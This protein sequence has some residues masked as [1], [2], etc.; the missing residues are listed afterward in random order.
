[1]NGEGKRKYEKVEMWKFGKC[2][3]PDIAS[4]FANDTMTKGLAAEVNPLTIDYSL[5]THL[6]KQGF[7]NSYTF[8][9]TNVHPFVAGMIVSKNGMFFCQFEVQIGQ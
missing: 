2:V 9:F 6:R 5:F 7:G 4:N 3:N 1:M 8:C